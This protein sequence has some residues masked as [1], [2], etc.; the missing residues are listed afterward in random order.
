MEENLKSS[1]AA[2]KPARLLVFGAV[3]VV[4]VALLAAMYSSRMLMASVHQ[5][6]ESEKQLSFS[7]QTAAQSIENEF[8]RQQELLLLLARYA[9]PQREWS[10]LLVEFDVSLTEFLENQRYRRVLPFHVAK[11]QFNFAHLAF[12]RGENRGAVESLN[13]AIALA[14]SLGDLQFVGRAKNTLGCVFATLGDFDSAEGL[15]R[16]SCRD[17]ADSRAQGAAFSIALRN[18]GLIRCRL[19]QDGSDQ[20]RDAIEILEKV[21]ARRLCIEHEL[22][23]DFRMTLCEMSWARGRFTLATELSEQTLDELRKSLSQIDSSGMGKTVI[24]RNRYVNAI[25]CAERNLAALNEI[26][27]EP[28]RRPSRLRRTESR[29]QWQRLCDLKTELVSDDLLMAGSLV[30]EFERQTGLVMAWGMYGW[31]H[32]VIVEIVKNTFDR[33]QVVVFADNGDSLDEAQS[34]LRRAGVPL[35]EIQFRVED[36]ETPWF[37]DPGPIVSRSASG[38]PVWFDS[39]LTRPGK[40]GRTVLD[41]LPTLLQRNWDARVADLP[42]HVEGGMVLSNGQGLV[43]ASAAIM[44]LNRGY[45]FSDDSIQRELRRATGADQL[46]FVDPLV[47][48]PTQHLDLFLTFVNPTTV[49]VAESDDPTGPNASHLN[50]VASRLGQ[51]KVGGEPLEVVPLPM[52]DRGDKRFPSYTNVVF[53]NGVLLV[54]SYERDVKRLEVGDPIDLRKAAPRMGSP[55]H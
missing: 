38:D 10:Y 7:D 25:R 36:C 27:A 22:L 24:A 43:L 15:F 19:G 49:V 53:A 55:I 12:L 37:R 44:E 21:G 9:T 52:P 51:I 20:V 45:G 5:L 33:T 8:Q 50:R 46:L 17:L 28:D 39:R 48:E 47:G 30:A 54:P 29:W 26:T 4:V 14:E 32:D 16:E 40:Y 31:S 1:V 3:V 2:R 6:G 23:Q 11:A 18:L 34:A 35:T 41:C 13:Q 42:I